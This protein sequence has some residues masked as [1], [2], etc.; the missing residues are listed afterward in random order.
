MYCLFKDDAFG[1]KV[2][3]MVA[4]KPFADQ[5][6]SDLKGSITRVVEVPKSKES[7]IMM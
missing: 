2:P 6:V 5:L 7:L 4:T 1:N 3:Y